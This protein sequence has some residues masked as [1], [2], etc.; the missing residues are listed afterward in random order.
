MKVSTALNTQAKLQ[1]ALEGPLARYM[2]RQAEFQKAAE[3]PLARY[4]ETQEKLRQVTEGPFARYM[5]HQTRL[6]R[7]MEGPLASFLASQERIQKVTKGSVVSLIEDQERLSSLV[8]ALA[9]VDP[10]KADGILESP[11]IPWLAV[12]RSLPSIAR[13]RLASEF[14]GIAI[15]VATFAEV[16]AGTDIDPTTEWAQAAIGLLFQIVG[17][18]LHV[19]DETES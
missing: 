3:G 18:L 9:T 12:A 6:Q 5:A 14:I 4:M 17:F 8:N 10:D 2:E 19:A 13:M 15:C 11:L 1:R 7:A 16:S